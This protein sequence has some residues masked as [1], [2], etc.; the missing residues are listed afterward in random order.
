MF[1]IK[2]GRGS[3]KLLTRKEQR[4]RIKLYNR[5]LNDS[6]MGR[7]LDR[8]KEAVRAWRIKNSLRPN[9]PVT[10][11]RTLRRRLKRWKKGWTDRQIAE[12]EDCPI[13]N[14]VMWRYRNELSPN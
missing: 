5:G 14:I 7:R 8:T 4:Q 9:N 11:P 3:H 13:I 10:S 6:E 1:G 2:T 12:R